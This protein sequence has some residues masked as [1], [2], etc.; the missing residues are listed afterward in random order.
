MTIRALLIAQKFDVK[1]ENGKNVSR[2]ESLE[3]HSSDNDVPLPPERKIPS[4]PC[5]RRRSDE[6]VETEMSPLPKTLSNVERYVF[7]CTQRI[8]CNI[9]TYQHHHTI[10][11]RIK[12]R[13]GKLKNMRIK[14]NMVCKEILS[15]EEKYV[16][17]MHLL[18]TCRKNMMT[19][20][21]DN[22]SYEFDL[23]GIFGNVDVI[24]GLNDILL[25]NLRRCNES[26]NNDTIGKI[27]MKFA[28]FLKLYA[29]YLK[30]LEDSMSLVTKYSEENESF[31]VFCDSLNEPLPSMLIRP[32]QQ[33]PRY[34]MLLRELL[35]HT[36]DLHPDRENIVQAID[37][38]SQVASYCNEKLERKRLQLLAETVRDRFRGQG[39][40]RNDMR[41]VLKEQSLIKVNRH[42]NNQERVFVLFNDALA[43]GVGTSEEDVDLHKVYYMGEFGVFKVK[44]SKEC[45]EVRCRT[46]KGM[47]LL[48]F[49]RIVHIT[50]LP[51]HVKDKNT[52]AH[53]F[54]QHTHLQVQHE[55]LLFEL[56]QRNVETYGSRRS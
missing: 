9:H 53:F 36:S 51:L 2:H 31:K 27:F 48:F 52:H 15:V 46:E 16:K 35:K 3:Y 37:L 12:N 29:V 56:N 44:D 28:P 26:E 45:F 49:I 34:V 50:S 23:D 5:L 55:S 7:H 13:V 21:Q 25:D 39:L 24:V 17:S 33:I 1:V 30:H 32:V 6:R 11:H 10:M 8:I 22:K 54:K 14:R 18:A 38:C 40:V 42:G 47:F 19:S 20:F 43:Y 4:S 41:H